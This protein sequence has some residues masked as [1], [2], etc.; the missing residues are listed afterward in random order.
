VYSFLRTAFHDQTS[1]IYRW[2]E[3]FV[4]VLIVISLGLVFAD[5]RRPEEIAPHTRFDAI[6]SVVLWLFVIELVLRVGSYHP[7]ILNVLRGT[8][9]YR[10]RQHVLGRIRFLF[11]PLVLLDVLA[12]LALVPAL[13]GLRA[14]RLLRLARSVR[15]FRYSTPI[16]GVTRSLKENGMLYAFNISFLLSGVGI[17]G[18]S[19]FLAERGVNPAIEGVA[20]GLW[21]ALVTITTVGYGDIT[22][23]TS[24]G[25]FIAGVLMITGMFTLALF[26]GTV[27]STL[28]RSLLSLREDTF[29]MSSFT[30]HFVVCG[31]D[32]SAT[33]LLQSLVSELHEAKTEI[34]V[35]APGDRPVELPAQFVWISGDPT[36]ESE[37]NKARLPLA[38]AAIIIGARDQSIQSADA[39]TLLTL[40]T[41]RSFLAKQPETE[42]RVQRLHVIAEILDPENRDHAAAA[43]ADEVVETTRLGFDLIAH[44]ALVPGSGNVMSSVAASEA[45]SLYIE[46][47]PHSEA[48]EFGELAHQVRDEYHVVVIGVRNRRSQRVEL[49]PNDT[50]IVEPTDELIYLGSGPVFGDSDDR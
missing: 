18:L 24:L 1:P 34:L 7:P 30:D 4:W 35:F 43:G 23:V 14:L 6:D 11:T 25:R 36:R 15:F 32:P 40:F 48:A 12:V 9:A 10:F 50:L 37:L 5:V 20:D 17:G 47:N 22:P 3:S 8:R 28:L 39:Q 45:D 21:W 46:E 33:L 31:Y 42:Q 49:N 29:R 41:L 19:L 27:G 26:A 2:V 38:R 16:Q 13:R 44:A